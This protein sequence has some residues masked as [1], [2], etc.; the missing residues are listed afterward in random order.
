MITKKPSKSNLIIIDRSA[1]VCFAD[2]RA[3]LSGYFECVY[4][5]ECTCSVVACVLFLQPRGSRPSTFSVGKH[6]CNY[7]G[8]S[9]MTLSLAG[10]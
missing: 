5:C 10:G 8:Q 6:P 2:S 1:G 9:A 4:A 7:Q 3:N